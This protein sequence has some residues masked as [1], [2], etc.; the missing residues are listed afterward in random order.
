MKKFYS[1]RVEF[2]MHFVIIRDAKKPDAIGKFEKDLDTVCGMFA[3]GVENLT[4]FDRARLLQIY[5]VAYHESGKIELIYS[6]D[7]SATNCD[8]CIKMRKAA[9]TNPDL[10]CGFCYDF[11]QEQY[12]KEVLNRH[13]L[14]LLIMSKIEFTV[15][16]LATLPGIGLARVNSSGD[17]ENVIYAKNMLRY[18]ISRGNLA[19]VAVW[20]K[21]VLAYIKAID[22]IGKPENVILIQSSPFINKPV[23][24][25][26]YFDYVFTVYSDA[27]AVRAAI[28]AGAC[29]CNGKKCKDCGFKCYLGAWEPGANIAEFLRK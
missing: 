9:E 4:A 16:E 25:A 19:K 12:R 7:S 27:D 21:N 1:E 13:S 22:E 18:A 8:F 3:K 24:R 29:E 2:G 5:K 23:T 26:K 11:K 17:A 20:S 28:E 6:L 15:E 14:N 10:I